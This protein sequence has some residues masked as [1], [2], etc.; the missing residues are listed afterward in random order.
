[1]IEI[2]AG[3]SIQCFYDF[4]VFRKHKI[5]PLVCPGGTDARHVRLVSYR[6]RCNV[7]LNANLIT[8]ISGQA[9]IPAIGFSPMNN[10]RRLIHDHDEHLSADTFLN[11]IE[12]Y[13]KL[14]SEVAN[15]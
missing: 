12:I 9:G 7:E 10:T 14:I 6:I 1:M 4:L 15:V 8:S 3:F 11:G 13:R 5:Q 2:C